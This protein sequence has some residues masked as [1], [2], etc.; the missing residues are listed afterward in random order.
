MDFHYMDCYVTSIPASIIK[1]WSMFARL[2]MKNGIVNVSNAEIEMVEKKE[3]AANYLLSIEIRNH[4]TNFNYTH[5]SSDNGEFDC[6][7]ATLMYLI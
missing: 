6:S 1:K 7:C 2:R 3:A 4:K 5:Y